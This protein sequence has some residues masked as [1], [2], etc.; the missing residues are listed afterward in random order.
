MKSKRKKVVDKNMQMTRLTGYAFLLIAGL[1]IAS[2]TLQ[3][4]SLNKN[5]MGLTQRVLGDEETKEEESKEEDKKEEE[6]TKEESKR[7][8]EQKRE[9]EK[10]IEETRKTESKSRGSAESGTRQKTVKPTPKVRASDQ[11]K[12][13]LQKE[14]E[15]GE[16]EI[17][18]EEGLKFKTKTEDDGEIKVESELGEEKVKYRIV[19]GQMIKEDELEDLDEDETEDVADDLDDDLDEDSVE[20]SSESG[21]QRIMKGG[22]AARSNFPLMVNSVTKELV[23]NT[24]A[25]EKVVSV[26]PDVAVENLIEA[27]VFDQVDLTE[28]SGE[29]E[30]KILSDQAVYEIDGTKEYR[31]FSIIPVTRNVKSVV[32][33]ETGDLITT[34][35]SL[36]TNIIDFLSP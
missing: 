1:A 15:K 28:T 8:E 17:E 4:L 12:M 23:I 31:I 25:G 10:R 13:E 2:N 27:G 22:V 30:L 24:P 3:A 16:L 14:G 9:T 33:A 18:T 34:E 5:S 32:S 20:I 36:L 6:K 29:L 19:N 11:V 26:L 21:R 35:K 7:V